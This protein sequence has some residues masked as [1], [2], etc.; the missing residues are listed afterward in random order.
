MGKPRLIR[1][2][3]AATAC[4]LVLAMTT[5]AM[6]STSLTVSPRDNCGGFNGH[7]VWSGGSSPYVQLY[8]EV[9]QNQC[10]S[11]DTS[12]W[13]AW[14]DSTYHN[15]QVQSAGAAK[16]QGVNDKVTTSATDMKVTVC[17]QAGG[18]HC[19]ASVAVSPSTTTTTTTPP[20]PAVSTPVPV[21]VPQPPPRPHVLSV[22]LTL[23]W[24][25]DDASTRLRKVNIGTLPGT[26]RLVLRCLGQG[27][28]RPA[29]SVAKGPR[30]V[31]RLLHRLQGRRYRAGDRLVV[32]LS[33]PG[34]IAERA[35]IKI[36]AGK[37]PEVRRLAT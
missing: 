33:A 11:G 34:W 4:G 19:G 36:R 8:G 7:V 6:A 23:S 30:R 35:Q 18:W 37:V 17:S 25:W 20:P 10:S 29:A 32:S 14:N 1:T 16:T 15:I 21:P 12:V 2:M 9:W 24:T 5:A 3:A 26:T 22:K 31:R 27:C 13:L 28:P